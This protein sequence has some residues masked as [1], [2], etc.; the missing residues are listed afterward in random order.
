MKSY[1]HHMSTDLDLESSNDLT[2]LTE[3]L[4]HRGLL[5]HHVHHWENGLWTARLTPEA[6]FQEADQGITATLT[7]VESLDEPTRSLWASCTLRQFDIG[8]ECGQE[9]EQ[10][11]QILTTAT[12]SKVAAISA[13]IMITLYPQIDI[14]PVDAAVEIL[15]KD[16][17]IKSHM[18]TYKGY[19]YKRV[20]L[21]LQK[22]QLAEVQV[23]LHGNKGDIYVHCR[24]ELDDQE[25]WRLK[26]IIKKEEKPVFPD[27]Y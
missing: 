22:Q 19:G 24:M 27:I 7:A 20:Y 23:T 2:P 8:Y 6:W 18:G 26:E 17:S 11:M 14:K 5:V 12:L 21:P 25:Q 10:F 9:P 4:A 15:K 3:A 16:K 13:S 1:T